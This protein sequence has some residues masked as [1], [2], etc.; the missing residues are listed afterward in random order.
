[1]ECE[2]LVAAFVTEHDANY[3]KAPKAVATESDE[4]LTNFELPAEQRKHLGMTNPIESTVATVS[5]GS[6]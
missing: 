2:K 3:P 5:C 6:A 4:L 1:V